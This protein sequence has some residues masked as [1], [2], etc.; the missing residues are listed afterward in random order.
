[1]S[2]GSESRPVRFETWRLGLVYIAV[3]IAMT[4]FLVRL[5]NLQILQVGDWKTLA[6]ENYTKE[7][8]VPAPRGIIYD[9]SGYIL[10]RNIASYNV[11]ITPANLP[12]DDSDIQRIYRELSELIDVP[13]GGPVT[14]E[15][16]EQA[17]LFAA[18]VAGPSIAQM[19]A[20][21]DTNAPFSPVKV[22][23][24]VSEE[25]AR[26]VEEKSV[27][28]PGVGVEIEP[29]RDYPTGSL[30]SHLIGFLGPIPASL[31][32]EY[33]AQ[34]FVPNRDKIGYSGI[35]DSL[36]DILAG[37]NGLRV[38]QVDVAGQEIRNLEPP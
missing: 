37:R 27:D 24:N 19:V 28:W 31:E 21:Q 12:A 35:E 4:A 36:Q 20:L 1:M 38:V 6:V 17:K 23:C 10:A 14:D 9:R 8:S 29:I 16:L 5:I 30:T 34:G 3:A 15:S 18:C 26:V 13:V 32:E 22:K 25:I 7:V 11:I 33:R 2:T